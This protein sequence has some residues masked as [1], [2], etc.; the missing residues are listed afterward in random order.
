[1]R[2]PLEPEHFASLGPQ[3][4]E[5]IRTILNLLRGRL[6]V[7]DNV[8]SLLVSHTFGATPDT[9]EN[10]SISALDI[11]WTPSYFRVIQVDRAAIVYTDPATKV[12]W[13]NLLIKAKCNVANAVVVLEVF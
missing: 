11:P 7:R 2:P 13:T 9:E 4:V 10:V 12:N 5:V 6:I 3:A 1:M 8:K